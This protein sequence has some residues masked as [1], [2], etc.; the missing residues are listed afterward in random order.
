VRPQRV[1]TGGAALLAQQAPQLGGVAQAPRP[2]LQ[3]DD[4]GERL[5]GR[6]ARGAAAAQR[7]AQ[8]GGTGQA[9]PDGLGHD[10][11]DP[12]LDQ[13]EQGL[14]PGQ[15]RLLL[16]R[17]LRVEH[18]RAHGLLDR[19]RVG[20]VDALGQVLDAGGV[21]GDAARVLLDGGEQPLA[22]PRHVAEQA[23][24]RGLARGQVDQHLRRRAVEVLREPLDVLRQQRRRR[25]P[26]RRG[27]RCRWR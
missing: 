4:R 18:A 5:L 23:L 22:Q 1:A 8:R 20:R 11:V 15:R 6:P 27:C 10:G 24:V 7:L 16:G 14:Q 19:G 3:P 13:R 21:D 26:G 17:G 2:Q 12:P 25:G 9:L